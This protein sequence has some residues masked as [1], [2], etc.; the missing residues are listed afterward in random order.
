MSIVDEINKDLAELGE[1]GGSTIEEA[2]DKLGDE[3]V[4]AKGE[5]DANKLPEVTSEDEGDILMV[6]SDGKWGKGEIP[7]PEPELPTVTSEDEGKVLTVNS[8]GAWDAETPSSGGGD[9]ILLINASYNSNDGVTGFTETI[10]TLNEA[11]ADGK[12]II[13]NLLVTFPG[14]IGAATQNVRVQLCKGEGYGG[15]GN[16]AY[17]GTAIVSDSG[18]GGNGVYAL[19]FW[20]E[21][22]YYD[23]LSL[24]IITLYS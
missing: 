20:Y 16:I 4:K 24:E 3:V 10:S 6:G 5:A 14:E 15:S 1:Q 22:D 11:W 23:T 8:E 2:M 21:P 13:L 7:A 12:I 9:N 18:S 19:Y 17:R